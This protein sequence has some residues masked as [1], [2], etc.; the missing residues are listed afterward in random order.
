MYI[1]HKGHVYESVMDM[2]DDV[3]E[4]FI[5]C[6]DIYIGSFMLRL[7]FENIIRHIHN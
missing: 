7:F 2:P 3:L 4:D 6:V 5:K 1:E